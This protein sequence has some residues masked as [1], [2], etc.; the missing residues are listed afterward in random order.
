MWLRSVVV[1]G[2]DES[3]ARCFDSIDQTVFL[4]DTPGPGAGK[5]SAER[6]RFTRSSKVIPEHSLDQFEDA[7]HA[8]PVGADPVLQVVQTV[9]V[10]ER[11]PTAAFLTCLQG[12][13]IGCDRRDRWRS[14]RSPWCPSC[15][16]CGACGGGISGIS[17][18][19]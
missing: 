14:S 17:A 15:G 3:Y 5:L 12:R 4:V 2:R 1:P 11:I 16:G 6:C 13:V 19:D 7:E 9:L 18:G 10:E 8:P